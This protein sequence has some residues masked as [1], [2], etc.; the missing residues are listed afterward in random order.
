MQ[1][2][3]GVSYARMFQFQRQDIQVEEQTTHE[4]AND[5]NPGI[6]EERASKKYERTAIDG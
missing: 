1:S 3:E 6:Q 5:T 4:E 2:K